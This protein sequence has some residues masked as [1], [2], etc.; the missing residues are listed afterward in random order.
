ME[1]K[2]AVTTLLQ[3][4]QFERLRTPQQIQRVQGSTGYIVDHLKTE[5][6]TNNCS[7][8]SSKRKKEGRKTTSAF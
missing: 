2:A 7:F 4:Q 3:S 5:K 6:G 1:L 8:Y